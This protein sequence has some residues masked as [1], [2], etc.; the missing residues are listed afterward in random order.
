MMLNTLTDDS[1]LIKRLENVLK[2][3]KDNTPL[4]IEDRNLL[5]WHI[6][7]VKNSFIY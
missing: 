1:V 7:I 3:L 6:E 5:S 4:N 2:K